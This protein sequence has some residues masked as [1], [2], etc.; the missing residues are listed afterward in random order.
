M[1]WLTSDDAKY[2]TVL[3]GAIH[4]I[5]TP[6]IPK[7]LVFTI[8]KYLIGLNATKF[9]SLMDKHGLS[10][11]LDDS[12]R[13]MTFLAPVNDAFDQFETTPGN[14]TKLL[15]YHVL[16]QPWVPKDLSNGLLVGTELIER[17]LGGSAQKLEVTVENEGGNVPADSLLK[18]KD[19]KS[20]TFGGALV[21]GEPGKLTTESF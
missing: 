20:I 12:S 19:G 1:V 17:K 6:I 11:Y 10:E 16:Q 14:F 9:V 15:L 13:Q 18:P 4:M 21:N 2:P 7:E 5:E 3:T 8:R